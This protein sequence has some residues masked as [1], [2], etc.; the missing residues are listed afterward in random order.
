V[1]PTKR[2]TVNKRSVRTV[3]TSPC[4]EAHFATFPAD[5]IKPCILSGCPVGGLVLDPFAGSGTTGMVA[6]ELGRKAILIELNPEYAEMAK[7]RCNV[8]P[9]L[10]V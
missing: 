3:P 1:S 5:L 7:Q 4:S 9:G 6:L 8:T 2:S 10:G